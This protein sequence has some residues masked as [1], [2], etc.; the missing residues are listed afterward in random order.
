MY[1]DKR[2]EPQS[3]PVRKQ[4]RENVI[5]V[6]FMLMCSIT[7]FMSLTLLFYGQVHEH[8]LYFV[9]V[10]LTI[11]QEARVKMRLLKMFGAFARRRSMGKQ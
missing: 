6:N 11:I 7:F 8:S 2:Q 10:T 5:Y 4:P 1:P 3:A 9:F